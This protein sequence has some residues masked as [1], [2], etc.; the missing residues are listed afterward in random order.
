MGLFDAMIGASSKTNSDSI[1]KKYDYIFGSGEEVYI[2]YKLV[3]DTIIF[4]NRRVI[5]I[6][7]QGVTGKKTE[8]LSVPYKS[9]VQFS[10]ETSGHIDLDSELKIWISGQG[11]TP[12]QRK[13]SSTDNL[14]EVQAVLAAAIAG[15]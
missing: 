10:V 4:T 6:D 15:K 8:Y 9:I 7:I 11:T 5:F 3:R 2:A 14:N 1:I 13:F 12:M